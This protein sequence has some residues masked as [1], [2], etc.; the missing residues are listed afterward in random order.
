VVLELEGG[1][2]FQE[3]YSSGKTTGRKLALLRTFYRLGVRSMQITHNGRNELCD[4]YREPS[5]SGLSGFGE[6]AVLE[7]NRLGVLVGV[8]HISDAGFSDVLSLSEA[9]IVA[10]HSNARAV[11][12]HPRNLTDSQ[13]KALAHNG[14]VAGMHFLGMMLREPTVEHYLNHVSHVVEVTGSTDHVGIG[15]HG[16][17]PVFNSLLPHGR[18]SN[19]PDAPDGLPYGEHLQRIMDG[20]ADRGFTDDQISSFMGGNFCGVLQRVLPRA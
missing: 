1:R 12:D 17:D 9:P 8:S 7:M 11:Y 16:F 10:T 19:P 3:D 2:P 6:A 5:G 14:G 13:L 18:G 15:I 20:L 4:S